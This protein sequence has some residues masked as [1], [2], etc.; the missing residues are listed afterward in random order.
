[1]NTTTHRPS[2]LRRLL[3]TG[4]LALGSFAAVA[5]VAPAAHAADFGDGPA[6]QAVADH[7]CSTVTVSPWSTW[8][9]DY[10]SFARAEVYYPYLGRWNTITSEWFLVDNITH[11]EFYNI[12]NHHPYAKITYARKISGTWRYLSDLVYIQD[13]VFNGTVFC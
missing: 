12:T 13:A 8:A 2:V 1:M 10:R 11:M 6:F 9:V 7:T 4:C 3:I 5:S